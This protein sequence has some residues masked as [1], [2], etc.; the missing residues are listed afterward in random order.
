MDLYNS[1]FL[2]NNAHM[3]FRR[4]LTYVL[5]LCFSLSS[6]AHSSVCV[7][8]SLNC[9]SVAL[10]QNNPLNADNIDQIR[11]KI[12]TGDSDSTTDIS[13]KIFSCQI[14]H[15]PALIPVNHTSSVVFFS[16]T[17]IQFFDKDF[18]LCP[19]LTPERPPRV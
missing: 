9:Q 7:S 6:V 10:F 2:G 11:A 17:E 3:S 12:S 18:K 19:A 14:C 15:S 13:Q 5:A 8:H 1:F 4:V 16:E